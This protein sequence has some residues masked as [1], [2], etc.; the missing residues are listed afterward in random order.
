M[1]V[2]LL[3]EGMLVGCSRLG[4]DTSAVGALVGAG[5]VSRGEAVMGG[6]R[7]VTSAVGFAVGLADGCAVEII[8]ASA[9][10][11]VSIDE[12]ATDSIGAS[13]GGI[14]AAGEGVGFVVGAAVVGA[15]VGVTV[16]VAVGNGGN[17]A[18]GVGRYVMDM[19]GRMLGI[20]VGG[21]VV[22]FIVGSLVG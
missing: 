17:V 9:G 10:G 5:V 2:G 21:A 4:N 15:A 16:G 12:G 11:I 1:A 13:A 6:D 8:G 19:D 20:I 22:G 18:D 7:P 14:V 3:V